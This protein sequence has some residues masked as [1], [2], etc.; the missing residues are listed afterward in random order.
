MIV[1]VL[2]VDSPVETRSVDLMESG[3]EGSHRGGIQVVQDAGLIPAFFNLP[4][5]IFNTGNT[6]PSVKYWMVILI[7]LRE[8]GTTAKLLTS[9]VFFKTL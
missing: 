8:G 6:C 9:L 3:R 4:K 2:V 5:K 1:L 7:S